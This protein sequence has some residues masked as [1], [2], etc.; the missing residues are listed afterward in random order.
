[1]TGRGE[2]GFS[3]LE[4][5]VALVLIGAVLVPLYSL[6]SGTLRSL[7]RTAESNARMGVETDAFEYVRSLNPMLAPEGTDELG[8]YRISWRS[9]VVAGP[10]NNEAYPAGIGAHDVGLYRLSVTVQTAKGEPVTSFEILQV[11][12]RLVRPPG[13]FGPAPA[14]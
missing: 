9:E 14:G 5:M 1:M 7:L 4:A 12:Y 3:L 10:R 13:L 6:H 2:A 11:G 8:E